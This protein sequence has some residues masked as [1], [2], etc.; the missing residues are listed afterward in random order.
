MGMTGA[1]DRQLGYPDKGEHI[2]MRHAADGAD[3]KWSKLAHS[4]E[5]EMCVV[6]AEGHEDDCWLAVWADPD[7]RPLLIHRLKLRYTK[8]A[9][10]PY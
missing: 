6:I 5:T 8:E 7:Q 10:I 9:L 2:P 4:F 3:P 1:H